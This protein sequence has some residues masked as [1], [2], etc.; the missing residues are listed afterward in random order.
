LGEL[1]RLMNFILI[2]FLQLTAGLTLAGARPV[3]SLFDPSR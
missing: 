1:A 2:P 3:P